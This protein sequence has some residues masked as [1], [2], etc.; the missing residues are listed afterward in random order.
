MKDIPENERENTDT[1]ETWKGFLGEIET[2]PPENAVALKKLE[3]RVATFIVGVVADAYLAA[4]REAP[5]GG[6]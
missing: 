6:V 3:E 2:K 1:A 5:P 4:A